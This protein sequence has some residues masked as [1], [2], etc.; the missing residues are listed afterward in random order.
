MENH[1]VTKSEPTKEVGGH[2]G[3]GNALANRR[4]SIKKAITYHLSGLGPEKGI[5]HKSLE[6]VNRW[7]DHG[8]D[9]QQMKAMD[10]VIKLLPYVLEKEGQVVG[11]TIGPNGNGV[12]NVQINNFD[13]FI[14]DRI[15]STNLGKLLGNMDLRKVPEVVGDKIGDV[16]VVEAEE[17]GGLTPTPM[18]GGGPAVE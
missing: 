11:G 13:S 1:P 15:S 8:T 16:G 3:S 2:K 17:V 9:D 12:I 5:I 7:L 4:K 6:K 14:K 18:P 10:I